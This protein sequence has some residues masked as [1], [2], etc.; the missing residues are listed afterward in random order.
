MTQIKNNFIESIGNTPLIKLKAASEITFGAPMNVTTVLL[1]S[2]PMSISSTSIPDTDS[3]TLTIYSIIFL[4]LP[5]EKLGTH[6]T[7]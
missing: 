1:V 7:I 4:S 6:S 5:S 2:A 3:I